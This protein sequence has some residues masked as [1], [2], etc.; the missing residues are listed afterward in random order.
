MP[1]ADVLIVSLG[2][3][4]GL[5]AADDELLGAL[6]RAGAVVEAV[7][8]RPVREVRTYM[9]TDLGWARAARSAAIAGIVAHRPRAVGYSTVTAALLWP[10]RGAIRYDA[11][12]AAN[13]PRPQRPVATSR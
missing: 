8:A 12:A 4:A 13:R 7:T 6:R 11:P 2:S 1:A 9:L 5:R 3:T 10:R